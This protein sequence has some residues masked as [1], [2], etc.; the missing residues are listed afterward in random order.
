VSPQAP[1]AVASL[2]CHRVLWL[3]NSLDRVAQPGAFAIWWD[4]IERPS[5]GLLDV[6][7]VRNCRRPQFAFRLL[8]EAGRMSQPTLA[9][10]NT[11]HL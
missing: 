11:A 1:L 4:A 10:I 6:L 2:A 3:V 9:D 7:A 5:K 8:V